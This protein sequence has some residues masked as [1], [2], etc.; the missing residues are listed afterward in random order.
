VLREL[1][2]LRDRNQVTLPS[3]IAAKL[4]VRPGDLLELILTEKG[5]VELRHARVVVAG[6]DEAAREER[7]AM[8]DVREG[9][10]STFNTP[11]EFDRY[12]DRLREQAE[13]IDEPV[14][15]ASGAKAQMP[16]SGPQRALK[17]LAE[18]KLKKTAG[19]RVKKEKS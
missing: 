1:V 19:Q 9:K 11:Q 14:A 4:S 7:L 8:N 17:K 6:T 3:A 13:K 18:M 10:Y 16:W 12:V 5:H 2:R 15:M